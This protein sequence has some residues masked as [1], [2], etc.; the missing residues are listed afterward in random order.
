MLNLIRR[1]LTSNF[2]VIYII[3]SGLIGGLVIPPVANMFL[4]LIGKPPHVTVLEG[5]L[6]GLIPFVGDV[7]ITCMIIM[8]I[9]MTLFV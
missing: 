6:I 2:I 8:W 5:I 9:I 3:I 1:R 4:D 7:V